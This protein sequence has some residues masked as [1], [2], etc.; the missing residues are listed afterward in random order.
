M[1]DDVEIRGAKT[2]YEDEGACDPLLLLQRG[3]CTN[4]PISPSLGPT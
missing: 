2:R 4:E 3:F 1:G